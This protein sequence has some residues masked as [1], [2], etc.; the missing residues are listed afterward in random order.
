MTSVCAASFTLTLNTNGSGTLTRNPTNALYPAGSVVT[1]KATPNPGWL[2]KGW[3][4]DVVATENPLNVLMDRSKSLTANFGTIPTFSLTISMDGNG[5][6]TLDPPG[7]TYVSNSVVNA[8]AT[9]MA[10]WIFT[11]WAQ[12]ES[13][14]S[15]QLQI[16]ISTNK[17]IR[18]VFAQ[19]P[20]IDRNP[21]NVVSGVGQDAAFHISAEGTSPLLYQW[22]FGGRLLPG[23]NNATLTL[24]NID[25]AQEGEYSVIVSNAYGIA[26]ASATL[27]LTNS[28][29]GPNVVTEPTE[30]SLRSAMS[31]GGQV[32]ICCNGII[33]LSST[34]DV[35][36][37]VTLDASD[38]SVTI[39]GNYSVRLFNV[40]RGV[41]LSITNLTLANGVHIGGNGANVPAGPALRGLPG[42]GAAI[43]ADGGTV[44][45]VRST[46]TGNA[47]AGGTGGKTSGSITNGP[48]GD[49]R[50][51]AISVLNGSLF[52]ESVK[53]FGNVANGGT[54]LLGASGNSAGGALYFTNGS[55]VLVGCILSNN[56]SFSPSGAVVTESAN[57]GAISGSSGSL[58]ISNCLFFSNFAH[59]S[60]ALSS[61]ASNP[62]PGSAS[63]GAIAATSG[64]VTIANSQFFAN[65][66]QGGNAYRHS[67][68]GEAQGGAIFTGARI[69]VWDSTFAEN[70]ARSGGGSIDS[71]LVTS[72]YGGAIYNVGTA[73]LNRSSF[74]SN[75][76]TGGDSGAIDIPGGHGWGGALFNEGHVEA[77]NCTFALNSARGG[78]GGDQSVPGTAFAGGLYNLGG[79]LKGV[80]ITVASNFAIGGFGRVQQGRAE[81]A[82]IVNTNGIFGLRNSLVAYPNT[83]GNA[84]GRITDDG[85]NISSDGSADFQGGSSFNFTDPRLDRLANYAGPTLSMALRAESPA[86]DL[87]PGDRAPETD[88]RGFARLTGAGV[89][90]GAYES[91]WAHDRNLKKRRISFFLM[92]KYLL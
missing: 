89:D 7:G 35:T 86:I 55:A 75:N 37:D 21:G 87:S 15:N 80:N 92:T 71:N 42:E 17:F 59:G 81:G 39:S 38:R 84:F 68:T 10:G 76:V 31:R 62:K 91:N 6:V 41:N 32:R 33:T 1:V 78:A 30:A 2:F 88:Q 51:G 73:G 63:G 61:T 18:A 12:D 4:G 52:L 70:Q 64:F 79:T 46:L 34:I 49:G 40:A 82:N 24:Q 65:K 3:S 5:F 74:Y 67:G 66:A 29:S 11:H 28:C 50:G 36:N 20:V 58:I 9:P 69:T 72:G 27:M 60:D 54:P 85:F 16:N 83:I 90:A 53:I 57:G 13:G 56:T 45:L 25:L 77:T 22:S 47:V 48:G 43:F 44:R 26:R 8:T 14:T 19:P 23:E